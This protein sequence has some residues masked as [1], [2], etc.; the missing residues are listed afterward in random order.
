[1]M[2]IMGHECERGYSQGASVG[3]KGINSEEGRE[4]KCTTWVCW[5]TA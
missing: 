3:G 2:T 1:M 5:K 4:L